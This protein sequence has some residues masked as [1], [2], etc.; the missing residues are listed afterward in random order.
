[1]KIMN[2][3]W[4]TQGF[5]RPK[6]HA[7]SSENVLKIKKKKTPVRISSSKRTNLFRVIWFIQQTK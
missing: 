5:F 2:Q 1:M 7:K 4:K 3:W 6:V